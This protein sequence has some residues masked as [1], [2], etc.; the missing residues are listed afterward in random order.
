MPLT[1][2][3]QEG[4]KKNYSPNVKAKL[5]S[6][7]LL[8]DDDKITLTSLLDNKAP[9]VIKIQWDLSNKNNIREC[10]QFLYKHRLDLDFDDMKYKYKIYNQNSKD[11]II[12]FSPLVAM[13]DTDVKK[14]KSLLI[15]NEINKQLGRDGDSNIIL[16]WQTLKAYLKSLLKKVWS[17]NGD[18]EIVYNYI[19]EKKLIRKSYEKHS[20]KLKKC[21]KTANI[22]GIPL[23]KLPT[24]NN[25]L[26][27]MNAYLKNS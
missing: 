8:N 21:F 24:T 9:G 7:L 27:R 11:T 19:K 10:N 25:H 13:T 18:E 16:Q 26:E 14:W 3:K 22:L 6:H 23:K 1:N 12:T 17:M 2:S 20:R 15:K 4:A 5:Y